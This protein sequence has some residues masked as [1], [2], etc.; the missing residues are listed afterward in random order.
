MAQ[1]SELLKQNAASYVRVAIENIGREFPVGL[2]H[3]MTG[4]DD[5][6][7]RPREIN[8]VFYGSYDW[9]S[10]VEMHWLLVRLLRTAKDLVPVGEIVETL[11]RQFDPVALLK[12]AEYIG[13]PDGRRERPYGW[14]WALTLVHEVAQLESEPA[15]RWSKA[16]MPLA[17][18]LNDQFLNWL[19]KATYPVRH[20]VHGNSAFGLGRALP[21]ARARSAAGDAR[22]AT[23]ITGAVARWFGSDRD[24]PAGW[25]PSGSDFL[26]PALVEAELMT[27]LLPRDQFADWLH[28]FLPGIAERRPEAIF[29]A[30]V[31]SD[32]SDGQ[33][34][35]LHGLNAS[36]AWCWRRIAE[37]LQEGDERIPVARQAAEIHADAS[38]PH[39][40]GDDYA[41]EHWL[42]AYAVLLLT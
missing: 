18:A 38:L 9:H 3:T 24:C 26:S 16:L 14:G 6:P 2:F 31:V 17:D 36:R 8:P 37:S 20:G 11:D 40:L 41:V 19:P 4:P 27:L 12:E 34:A 23:A 29:R 10:C 42:A 5:L 22:L 39:V 30:A 15:A 7:R 21:Y 32:S 33:I 13:G 35:H 1:W 25:E 28:D